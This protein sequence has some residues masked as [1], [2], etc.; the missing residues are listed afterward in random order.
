LYI[1]QS[2]LDSGRIV[3]LW[4]PRVSAFRW[5]ALIDL[6]YAAMFFASATIF[7]ISLYVAA[8]KPERG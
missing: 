4:M 1:D 5:T 2:I 7:L 3:H 8:T 6:A